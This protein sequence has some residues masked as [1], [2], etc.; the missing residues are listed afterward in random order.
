MEYE[1]KARGESQ[2]TVRTAGGKQGC[3]ALRIRR[4]EGRAMVGCKLGPKANGAESECGTL[5][6][7]VET[8]KEKR[9]LE[10]GAGMVRSSRK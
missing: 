8:G 2:M 10:I 3:E 1:K 6:G 9:D 4:G 5:E 7:W